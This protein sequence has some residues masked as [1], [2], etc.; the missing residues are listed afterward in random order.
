MKK[1]WVVI[2]LA[3]VVGIGTIVW[4]RNGVA[5]VNP[6]NTSQK[7]FVIPK[8]AA[9][10]IIG[11]DLKEQ[12]LIKDPV[13]FF[14]YI[15]K[16]RLDKKI[17]AGSYKLS[18]SMSLSQ[19]VDEMRKGTIDVWV[20]IPEGYRAAEIAE[21]LKENIGTYSD[22]WIKSLEEEEGYLFPDTYLI[23][24]DADVTTVISIMNNNFYAKIE[25]I[26]LSKDTKN[27]NSIVTMASLIE[28][29]AITDSEKPLIAS[30]I[31]NRLKNDM[32][33]DIDATLQYIKGKDARG[34]WW[35]VPTGN[36][37]NLNSLYNTYKN[38]GLPPGPIA[39]PGLE[40]IRAAA[41]PGES[42]YYFYIHDTT[43]KVHF[44]RTL[45]EHNR[46]VE[47]YLR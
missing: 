11:N 33:L 3:V 27:L 15:K 20:T 10:R 34:K 7:V 21:V 25:S 24:K 17:Q 41:N 19:L 13:V 40:A 8:G 26:E 47:K 32:A 14:L 6:K 39:N 12:G 23:P 22:T 37:K 28:R 2:L 36:D 45:E 31:N 35:S 42:N 4:W 9:I 18:P 43:G 29:E 5:P 44:A 16:N 38:I 30:V 1:L 46:N